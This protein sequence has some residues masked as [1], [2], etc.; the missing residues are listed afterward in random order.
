MVLFS[1]FGAVG[2]NYWN[3]VALGGLMVLFWIFEV[4]PIYVT[5][6]LP[7][8]LAIP[9]GVLTTEDLA[10]Q[11]GNRMVFLFFGG[12]VLSL[13]LEKWDVHKR[14]AEAIIRLVGK[15]PSRLILGFL[16]AT[17]LLSMWISNTA[18]ALM[19]LPMATAV[20]HSAMLEKTS[21]VPLF[22]MLAIAYGA[23][24]GGMATIVGSPPNT[25]M[26]GILEST[27]GISISFF[28]WMKFG[29][30]ISLIMLFA[31]YLVFY[32]MLGKERKRVISIEH[33]ERQ[34]WTIQQKSVLVLFFVVVVLWS[35][36]DL[37]VSWTGID[38]KDEGPA[39]LGAILLFI[40]PAS[41]KS[42]LLEWKDTA[43]LPWGVLLLFGGGLALA[44]MME[45][46]GVVQDVSTVFQKFEGGSVF[47]LLLLLVSISI[48]ATEVMSNLALVNVLVP[49]VATFAVNSDFEVLQLCLPVT[50][51]ASCA[52]MLPVS[53]PPNAIVFSSGNVTISS[54]ARV[55]FVLNLIGV[56]IVTVFSWIFI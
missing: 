21:R 38:Y 37:F 9:L 48:Y 23:S 5:A 15:S 32:L 14:I 45:V 49:V 51:A 17:A 7:L 11:Y 29:L 8:V 18:T 34:K 19:M 4:I 56:L 43:K 36:R 24:L 6:L 20:I 12:F 10:A 46:N 13:A 22:L 44:K 16:L 42:T 33:P 41:K 25:A 50:L 27:Y 47:L 26:V 1:P 53:T 55:G 52:F 30:P 54:M 39:M 35:F 31:V 28:D 2:D 40:I 3:A